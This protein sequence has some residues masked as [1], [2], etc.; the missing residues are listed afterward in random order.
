MANRKN[1]VQAAQITTPST[2]D[3]AVHYKTREYVTRE[4]NP[5]DQWDRDDTRSE[6]T[7]QFISIA[8]EG[9]WN[10]IS[11]P[12]EVKP[13][14]KVYLLFAVYSTG[15]S[16]GH[17]EDRSVELISVHKDLN[18]AKYNYKVLEGVDKDN[19]AS[20]VVLSQDDGSTWKMSPPWCGYFE[21][22]S[23][24]KVGGFTVQGA[25]DVVE[26]NNNYESWY[27]EYN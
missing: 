14:D 2:T 11:Y 22:L 24:L 20:S 16:F 27:D 17:D 6:H 15:D 12:G 18:C 19:Y 8:R 26:R 9:S 4:R 25:D 5:D 23:Y 7:M 21:S 13:G 1:A 3:L 10:T